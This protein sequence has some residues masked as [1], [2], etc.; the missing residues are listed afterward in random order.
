MEWPQL[1]LSACVGLIAGAW[2]AAMANRGQRLQRYWEIRVAAYQAV[3]EA[4]SDCIHYYEIHLR[5]ELERQPM[6]PEI[7]NRLE[8][9][10]REAHAKL[11]K[12]ADAG[13]FIFSKEVE[14]AIRKVVKDENFDTFFEHV[15]SKLPAS[16]A[17]L[18]VIVDRSIDDLKVTRTFLDN[19]Q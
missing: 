1:L 10:S 12:A 13:S 15:E 9:L 18:K 11:R 16:K 4:L 7:H 8:D 2:G 3:I 19:L 6:P 17:C 14:S 5:H